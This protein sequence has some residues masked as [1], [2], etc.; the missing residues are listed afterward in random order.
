MRIIAAVQA[1]LGSTR[2]PGKVLKPLLGKPMLS[3]I[4]ERLSDS[5]HITELVVI[6]PMKDFTDISRAVPEFKILADAKIEENDLV[7]R[8]WRTAITFGADLVVRV[9]SDNAYVDPVN[10][11]LLIKDYLSNHEDE[12]ILHSNAGDYGY[13]KWPMGLGA[14]IY[15]FDLLKDLNAVSF[16]SMRE[17]PHKGF[18]VAGKV[19]EPDCPYNWDPPLHFTI[20][21]Q[22]DFNRIENIYK[23]FGNNSTTTKELL[24]YETRR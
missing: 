8:Y 21:T 9:C 4:M 13:S 22:E 6:V 16:S 5:K 12:M 18:H 23:Y 3:H 19:I 17:H 7:G 20:N 10:I 15:S 11:D 24:E 2:L 14:E 1:R